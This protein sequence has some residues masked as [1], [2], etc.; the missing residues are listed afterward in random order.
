MVFSLYF[1]V[2]IFVI[3]LQ[4]EEQLL[5][6]GKALCLFFGNISHDFRYIWF[7]LMIQSGMKLGVK[8]LY[9]PMSVATLLSNYSLGK[10]LCH[11]VKHFSFYQVKYFSF[12]Q[13][14]SFTRRIRGF[15]NFTSTDYQC[16]LHFYHYFIS[17][18]FRDRF[19][20]Q[21]KYFS[22][23]VN[24]SRV[25]IYLFI[26]FFLRNIVH[27]IIIIVIN[28]DIII[29]IIIFVNLMVYYTLFFINFLDLMEDSHGLGQNP[30]SFKYW[31]REK[32]FS[33]R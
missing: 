24:L 31:F 33:L 10:V 20:H 3:C 26:S 32:P 22:F 27:F 5:T 11:Q 1:R 15:Y 23:F 29:V 13:V 4:T 6:Q 28:R 21:V 16:L 2:S 7:Y 8:R 9:I 30:L 25:F 17:L 18:K 19:Y 12:Y 14:R